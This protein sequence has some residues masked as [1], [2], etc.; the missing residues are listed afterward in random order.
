MVIPLA[1]AGAMLVFTTLVHAWATGTVIGW[2]GSDRA[3]HLRAG[4]RPRRALVVSGVVLVMFFAT[5]VETGAWAAV[6]LLVGAIESLEESLY[7]SLVTFTTLGFG[8]V[9]LEAPFRILAAFE[10]ANGVMI[11]GWTTAVIVSTL[12]ILKD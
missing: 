9:V 5:L 6:F 2:V 4:S 11:F 8:D 1:I 7:F 10:A 3:A 12:D